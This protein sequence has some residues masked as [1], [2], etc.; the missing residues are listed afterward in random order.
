MRLEWAPPALRGHQT[1]SNQ[2]PVVASPGGGFLARSDAS[3]PLIKRNCLTAYYRVCIRPL[4]NASVW[5]RGG[6]FDNLCD[7]CATKFR[8][9]S[10]R[11]AQTVSRCPKGYNSEG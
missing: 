3:L 10:V 4:V 2:N 11:L 5:K 1:P 9:F 7:Y 8:Y 6:T